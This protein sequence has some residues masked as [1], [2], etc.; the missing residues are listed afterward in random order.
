M[1]GM[2]LILANYNTPAAH[3]HPFTW[4]SWKRRGRLT[5][6][7]LLNRRNT[8]FSCVMEMSISWGGKNFPRGESIQQCASGST[9]PVERKS[10]S[11]SQ[12]VDHHLREWGLDK[13]QIGI[14]LLHILPDKRMKNG[15]DSVCLQSAK[16]KRKL[17]REIC[18]QERGG[19]QGRAAETFS[20]NIHFSYWLLLLFLHINTNKLHGYT[21]KETWK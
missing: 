2:E 13:G 16:Y 3:S 17:Q 14:P 12:H 20:S 10:R 18:L 8:P 19:I 11:H 9:S 4:R 21:L 6:L 7:T 1:K 15:A 5:P